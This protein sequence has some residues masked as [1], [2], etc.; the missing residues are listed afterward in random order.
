MEIFASLFRFAQEAGARRADE[1]DRIA[2]PG[3]RN[4]LWVAAG[5]LGK[6]RL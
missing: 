4:D 3:C 1:V 2:S 5:S 6:Q